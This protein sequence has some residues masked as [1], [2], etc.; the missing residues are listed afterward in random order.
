MTTVDALAFDHPGESGDPSCSR[1]SPN[2]SPEGPYGYYLIT[3]TLRRTWRQI[4]SEWPTLF[5]A[6][7]P[8]ALTDSAE[9]DP[10]GS[11]SI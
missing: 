5:G 7:D 4:S 9:S 8:R 3:Q 10:C 1:K 6:V 2:R 11:D